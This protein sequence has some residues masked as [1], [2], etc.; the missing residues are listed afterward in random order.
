MSSKEPNSTENPQNPQTNPDNSK[1]KSTTFKADSTKSTKNPEK[2]VVKKGNVSELKDKPVEI[3]EKDSTESTKKPVEIPQKK[4][5]VNPKSLSNLQRKGKITKKSTEITPELVDNPQKFN[6]NLP[7]KALIVIAFAAG[8]TIGGFGL[9]KW[10]QN[11]KKS[12][13]PQEEQQGQID[14]SQLPEDITQEEYQQI[15]DYEASLQ[16]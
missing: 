16:K 2:I 3:P 9:W 6:M 13:V 7:V 10:W 12:E 14:Y 4:S 11:R 8:A 15:L 1:L 5:K